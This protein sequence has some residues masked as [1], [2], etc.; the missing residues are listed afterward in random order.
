MHDFLTA[1]LVMDVEWI[2]A[3]VDN[4]VISWMEKRAA[5]RPVNPSREILARLVL[6][7]LANPRA[8]EGGQE[9]V[10]YSGL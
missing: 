5:R 6:S 7:D 4:D 10:Q 2:I 3:T 9:N 8:M 1:S